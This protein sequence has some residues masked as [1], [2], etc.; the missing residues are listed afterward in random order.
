MCFFSICQKKSPVVSSN[1][2]TY[3]LLSPSLFSSSFSFSVS[4]S[5]ACRSLPLSGFFLSLL[6]YPP[7]LL[8][9]SFASS[10]SRHWQAW[11]KHAPRSRDVFAFLALSDSRFPLLFSRGSSFFSFAS[12]PSSVSSSV[13]F[14]LFAPWC[15]CALDVRFAVF[16]LLLLLVPFRHCVLDLNRLVKKRRT[17]DKYTAGRK[18]EGRQRGRR[19][20]R[21]DG[22]SQ[23]GGGFLHSP[24]ACPV[25][26]R[27]CTSLCS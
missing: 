25:R 5:S 1:R 16:R 20:S 3:T 12:S 7:P 4:G 6:L 24:G 26:R 11:G 14:L 18:H 15:P 8:C 9:F 21:S 2:L 19:R 23:E 27:S 13:C 10:L 17:T 22:G